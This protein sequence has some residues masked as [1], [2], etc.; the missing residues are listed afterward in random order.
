MWV[1]KS[2]Y[3]HCF[4]I[5]KHSFNISTIP[6][7]LVSFSSSVDAV[8]QFDGK[9]VGQI[10]GQVDELFANDIAIASNRSDFS[11]K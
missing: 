7:R 8:G 6:G 2:E 5:K 11:L 9:V 3:H 4:S 10:D 1:T